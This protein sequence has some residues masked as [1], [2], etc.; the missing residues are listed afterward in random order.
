MNC[1]SIP[2]LLNAALDDELSP[3]ERAA[4]QQ[5]LAEC[6]SCQDQWVELQALHRDL[7]QAVF[8]PSV[9]QAVDRV[10]RTVRANPS[11]VNPPPP[12]NTS[13]MKRSTG[14]SRFAV[15]AVVCV[16]LAVATVLQLSIATPAIAEIAMATGPI[17]FKPGNAQHWIAVDGT[18]R[19]SLSANTRVRTRSTSLCEIHTKSNGV[20]RLNHQTELVMRRAEEVELVTGELWCRAPAST[21]LLICGASPLDQS[22]NANVFLCP[23]ATEMQWHALPNH[24][25]SCQDVAATPVEIKLPQTTCSIQPGECVTFAAGNILPEQTRRSNPL[26]ATG[27]QLPLLALRNPR[28]AELQDRLTGILAVAGE[29]KSTYLYEDQIRQ[30]GS[31]GALPLLAFVQSPDSRQKPDVRYRAMRLVAELAPLSSVAN[32]EALLRDDDPV[33][34][35]LAAQALM[36][37]QPSRVFPKQ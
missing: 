21:G 8:P 7:A 11:V 5:H 36:R 2:L 14:H 15:F 31:S 33:V 28:D 25:L 29:A 35:K 6:P 32:L 9:D 27:W 20:V 1:E 10:L 4:M 12:A 22:A 23:S 3:T 37:L 30:L 18:T 34:R 16:L 26:S 24:E 19:V 13:S 17:D